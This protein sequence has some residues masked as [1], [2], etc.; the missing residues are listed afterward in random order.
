MIL[1]LNPSVI[2]PD[3]FYSSAFNY[4]PSLLPKSPWRCS[5][6][7]LSS[8]FP[9][10]FSSSS[11]QLI[12]AQRPSFLLE[13]LEAEDHVALHPVAVPFS[14]LSPYLFQ[15]LIPFLAVV[16]VA[17][18]NNHLL[19]V[20]YHLHVVCL[21]RLVVCKKLVALPRLQHRVVAN[22]HAPL[23]HVVNHH[24]AVLNN[25]VPNKSN[26]APLHVHHLPLIPSLHRPVVHQNF[27]RHTKTILLP[28]P[29][30]LEVGVP[31]VV[32]A[33]LLHCPLLLLLLVAAV[34][35]VLAL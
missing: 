1:P 35:A 30:A 29:L 31:V 9:S 21:L 27:S 22:H 5:S 17:N 12:L 33:V 3:S 8:F 16:A 2:F 11:F 32:V 4:P 14:N 28:R 34:E 7:P 15:C 25:V 18:V 13:D 10:K 23:P 20:A 6:I 19:A 26:A 24:L